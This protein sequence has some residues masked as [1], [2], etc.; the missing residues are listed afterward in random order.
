MNSAILDLRSLLANRFPGVRLT[1]APRPRPESIP[2]GVPALDALLEGGLPKGEFTELIAS[3]SGTG[4]AEV[5]HELMRQVALKRRFVAL[6]DGMGS[7]DPGA[8]EPAVLARVLWIQCR[9]ATE[10]FKATDLI[11]RDRNFPV[12]V[13]DLK[14]NPLRELR[15]INGSTWYR[16]ARLLEH[17][18]AAVLVVVPQKMVSGA[19]YAVS[20]DNALGIEALGRPR[21]ERLL[22]LRFK[23]LKSPVLANPQL[24][25]QA[26]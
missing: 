24:A 7:F 10:A 2:T 9:N 3:G 17:N 11:L 21:A 14:M 1:L 20:C 6:V 19:A 15:K 18:Q 16:Y 13:L 26:S 12:L 4:S 25:A 8:I 23:Q 22:G 5:I